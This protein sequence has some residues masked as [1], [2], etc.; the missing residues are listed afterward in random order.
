ML[1]W[2]F[3]N[4]LEGFNNIVKFTGGIYGDYKRR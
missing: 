3:K 4:V 2:I 1:I